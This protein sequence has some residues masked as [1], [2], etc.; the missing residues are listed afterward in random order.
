MNTPILLIT[1]ILLPLAGAVVLL[2][3]G[4]RDRCVVR[5]IALIVTLTTLVAAGVLVANF[6]A[7]GHLAEP[8]AASETSWLG[9]MSGMDVRFSVAL[10]GLSLW[11]FALSALLLAMYKL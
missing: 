3:V 6:P 10:D 8:F 4:S 5:P 1:A 11:L 7:D 2:L 9:A